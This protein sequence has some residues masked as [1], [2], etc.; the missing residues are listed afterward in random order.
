MR[1]GRAGRLYAVPRREVLRDT[2]EPGDR[3]AWRTERA[4]PRAS[5]R[6]K[7]AGGAGEPAPR[8][9]AAQRRTKGRPRKPLTRGRKIRRRIFRGVLAVFLVIFGYVGYT[10]EPY[11]TYAGSDTVAARVAEWG[12]DHHLSWA[13][14]WLE[15][16]TYKAPPTGGKLSSQQVKTLQGATVSPSQAAR[17]ELP[18]NITP[19]ALGSITDEGVLASGREQRR[20]RADRRVGRSAPRRAAHLR[21]RVRLVD[22]PEGPVLPVAPRLPAARRQLPDTDRHPSRLPGRTSSRRGT[23]ASRSTRTIRWAATT[24]TAR[25]SARSSPARPP[26]CSTRTVRSRSA[27]GA[28]T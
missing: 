5:T 22:E 15:N 6:T 28:A 18:A 14:T 17:N 19:L 20:G 4:W 10:I 3:S 1:T 11:L 27:P 8:Q 2:A 25:R 12:R 21:A 16:T 13:V 24:R 7:Q 26:R 23:A 9:E